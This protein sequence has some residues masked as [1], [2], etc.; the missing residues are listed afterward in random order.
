[1]TTIAFDKTDF[2]IKI[3]DNYNTFLFIQELIDHKEIRNMDIPQLRNNPS[4]I[5]LSS[6]EKLD[7]IKVIISIEIGNSIVCNIDLT[8]VRMHI[9]HNDLDPLKVDHKLL[10]GY[11]ANGLKFSDYVIGFN[12]LNKYLRTIKF[13]N[14]RGVFD[15][16]AKKKSLLFAETISRNNKNIIMRNKIDECSVCYSKTNCKTPCGHTLCYYCWDKINPVEDDD[17]DYNEKPC[18]ICRK[19]IEINECEKCRD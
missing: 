17:D 14:E 11:K 15:V 3:L 1:M 9:C 7:N 13:H 12:K 2:G 5:Q 8:N 6:I 19:N 10:V 4:I 18:P 16:I